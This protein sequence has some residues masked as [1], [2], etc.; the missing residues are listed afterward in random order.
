MYDDSENI[1]SDCEKNVFISCV[2]L[3][4]VA[5]VNLIFKAFGINISWYGPYTRQIPVNKHQIPKEFKMV[6][7][8]ICRSGF[9]YQHMTFTTVNYF[10]LNEIPCSHFIAMQ[11]ECSNTDYNFRLIF[12]GIQLS[13]RFINQ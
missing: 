11:F 4:E 5:Y 12:S 13:G 1:K 9:L 3:Y 8:I 6:S 10:R 2:F 7:C